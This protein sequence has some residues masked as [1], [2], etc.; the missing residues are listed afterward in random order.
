[1]SV[2]AKGKHRQGGKQWCC[3]F[4]KLFE[5]QE[6]LGI[7][8]KSFCKKHLLTLFLPLLKLKNKSFLKTD[9]TKIL[10][11]N[12]IVQCTVFS[13]FSNSYAHQKWR[14]DLGSVFHVCNL[15]SLDARAGAKTKRIVDS[16][17]A[18]YIVSSKPARVT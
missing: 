1:M 3:L 4:L 12:V 18:D 8:L 6:G 11:C 14:I 16:R 7:L 17:P 15:S 13:L 10:I 5:L 2:R 9:K